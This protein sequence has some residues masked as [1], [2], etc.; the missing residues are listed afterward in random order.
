[1]TS[2]ALARQVGVTEEAVRNWRR[3][4]THPSLA[5]LPRIAAALR[6][7]ADPDDGGIGDPL[8]L[9][10]RMNVISPTAD[11]AELIDTAHRLQKLELKLADAMGRAGAYGRAEGAAGIVRA[12]V[13][14]GTWAVAV[15]PAIEGTPT[16]QM[17][18]ADRVD[19][20]RTDGQPT[21]TQ[22]VWRDPSMKAAL[23]AAYAVPAT[24]EPRWSEAD[25][26]SHWAIS[27]VGSPRNPIVERP[28]RRITSLGFVALTA[29]SW[30]NDVASLVATALGY[31][32][33]TTRDLAM[34]A[35]GLTSGV[36]LGSQRRTAHH[37]LLERPPEAGAWSHH[38]PLGRVPESPFV[39]RS[40]LWRQDVAFVWIRESDELL[41]RWVD[42]DP[43]RGDVATLIADRAHIDE[44]VADV[45][46]RRQILTY[47]VGARETVEEKWQQVLEAVSTVLTALVDRG[48]LL[49]TEMA[50]VR[51][52]VERSDPAISV[53]LMRW[54]EA[55]GCMAVP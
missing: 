14:S 4:K 31:G 12:A 47:Q 18:V 11:D 20:K 25:D 41:Q 43:S 46:N 34:E 6:M 48:L 19:V 17:H 8:Y 35:H 24:R 22:L 50:A 32:L 5:Q 38:A 1:M 29:S 40:G 33:T 15:W 27:H 30:V 49:A 7:G 42:N 54:L 10:R 51:E 16:C 3:G 23:R 21:T 9:L 26:V 39:A 45:P 13:A 37:R 55:D 52:R 28:Y 53:P 36:T 44:F 2:G